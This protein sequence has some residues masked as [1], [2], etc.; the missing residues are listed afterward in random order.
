VKSMIRLL[1]LFQIVFCSCFVLNANG[2]E[3]DVPLVAIGK[4][5][6]DRDKIF[7]APVEIAAMAKP[8]IKAEVQEFQQILKNDFSFYRKRF[9]L[10]E[11][12]LSASIPAQWDS[13]KLKESGIGYLIDS[14]FYQDG[15]YKLSIKVTDTNNKYVLFQK[16]DAWPSGNVLRSWA[17]QI[18]NEIFKAITGKS[19][20]FLTKIIFVSDRHSTKRRNIKEIYMADFDGNNTRRITH[21][22]GTVISPDI[23]YDGKKIV[24]SLISDKDLKNRRINLYVLD[25][26]TGRSELVSS[27]EG[28]NSGA[29][30]MPDNEN[31]VLTLS[32]TGNAEIYRLNIRNKTLIRI[33]NHY[34]IDVDPSMMADGTMM[35]FLSNRAGKA[36]VYVLDPRAEEKDVRRISYVGQFNAT[37]RFS[38]DGKE[39]VFVSWLD[40]T[41]DIFRINTDG[42]GLV[43]LTKDFGSCEEPYYSPDGQ[44]IV[45]SARRTNPN[46]PNID[47]IYVMDRDGEII[48]PITQNMGNCTT[49]RW[50]KY[51]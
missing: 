13:S 11:E 47:N 17:H 23:S 29:M 6:P 42:T 8:Q 9:E 5:N 24:Y 16:T 3:E 27:M 35:A 18:N 14:K 38:P 7:I 1:I 33:T 26:T 30:W 46:S 22:N 40:S 48:G 43:R 21:H 31:V 20:I 49:P 39:I 50:S 34:A 41:F 44:F 12:S 45:F 25:L 2:E 37:P 32:F 36:N 19:S 51:L 10:V 15:Q 4:A 28:I